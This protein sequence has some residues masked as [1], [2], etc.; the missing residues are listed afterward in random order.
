MFLLEQSQKDKIIPMK[1]P[2]E[3][4]EGRH[5]KDGEDGEDGESS[6][7]KDFETAEIEIRNIY[8]TMIYCRGKFT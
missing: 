2:K 4:E 7:L 8:Y 3:E 6:I 1:S 5:G